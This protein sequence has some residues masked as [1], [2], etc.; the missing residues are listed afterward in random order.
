MNLPK[1]KSNSDDNSDSRLGKIIPILK[2]NK[3]IILP[4]FFILLAILARYLLVRRS[5]GELLYKIKKEN[6]VDTVKVSGTYTVASQTS[7]KSPAYGVI[8]KLYVEDGD[9]VEKGDK[10][11]HIESTA[12]QDEVSKA[13]SA[14]QEALVT[15]Q[16][17]KNNLRDEEATLANVYDELQGHANDETFAQKQTR[18]SAEV[19]KDNAYIA[20]T[21]DQ[22]ALDHA[23]L[24]YDETQS[25]TVTSPA[26]GTVVNL[27]KREGDEVAESSLTQPVLTVAN[28]TDPHVTITYGEDYALR[29]QKGQ[30]TKIVFDAL[31]SQSFNGMVALLDTVGS[32]NN[33]VV[34][35]NARVE[36]YD[37]PKNIKPGMSALITI[38][39]LRKNNVYDVPN[40][41]L[42]ERD[43]S[44]YLELARSHKLI[45][46]GVGVK[47]VAKSE[48]TSGVNGGEMIVSNPSLE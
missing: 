18:T 15:L 20:V 48:V 10:L 43:G 1:N 40:G 46:V 11:F 38:E 19:A 17:A 28:L 21:K 12:T 30:K 47:G 25:T 23:K 3:I 16:A 4:I 14:Y 41:S 5:S 35:Y 8:T 27:L 31:K 45:E 7:V 2:K 44:Y 37:L 9:M 33:G 22:A 39:T 34:T 6:L 36:S 13:Y 26:G 42:I 24:A 29:I 32:V